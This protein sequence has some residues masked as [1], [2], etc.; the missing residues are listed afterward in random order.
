MAHANNESKSETVAVNGHVIT[1]GCRYRPEQARWEPFASVRAAWDTT[2][3]VVL[4]GMTDDLQDTPEDAMGVARSAADA[5][6]RA[7]SA[8]KPGG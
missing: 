3:E 5:W 4:P 6:L 7:Q 1:H 2:Q 8:P